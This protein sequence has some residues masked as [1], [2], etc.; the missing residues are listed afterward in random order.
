M[1]QILKLPALSVGN[2][3]AVIIGSPDSTV[4]PFQLTAATT[5]LVS[6]VDDLVFQDDEIVEY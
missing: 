3:V 1:S 6:Y 4:D 5:N 2:P